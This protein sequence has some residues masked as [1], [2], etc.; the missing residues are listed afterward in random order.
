MQL[1][2]THA[3][4]DDEAF[5]GDL[6]EVLQRAEAAGMVG[7]LAV[8]ISLAS[9]EAAISLA[10]RFAVV[11]AAVGIH[12]NYAA[13][14][15]PL[16][17]SKLERLAEH[18]RVVA[19]GETGLD[20]HWAYT[21]FPVQEDFLRRHLVLARQT[22][23]PIVLHCREAEED[24]LRILQEDY[25][26]NGPI[27]GMLH[28]F[29]G[30]ATMAERGLELGLHVSFAGMVTYKKAENLRQ[31]AA[32]VPAERL[33]IET[34]SPYLVP[35]PLR[36]PRQRNEPSYLVHTLSCLAKVRQTDPR[37]LAAI[38]TANAQ[39]LLRIVS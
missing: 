36:G 23:R 15:G 20:R 33:L 7:I 22:A 25:E 2:D 8:G 9:S 26:H 17:W 5:V 13:Q 1:F 35:V 27:A 30:T 39:R 29:S 4:L 37:T 14:A 19:V 6:P 32:Q 12:P 18:P 34:D 38:T 24:L 28:A 3:H 16:D 31:I 21:P 10:E 11:W